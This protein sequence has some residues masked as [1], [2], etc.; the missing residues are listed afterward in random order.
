M[1]IHYIAISIL[2]VSMVIMGCITYM[3]SLA[4]EYSQ[5]IDV[6]GLNVSSV[7]RLE[8][9]SKLSK[10][11]EDDITEFKIETGVD[12]LL[13]PYQFFKVGWSALKLQLASW[14]TMFAIITDGAD[15]FRTTTGVPLPFWL[16]NGITSIIILVIV[17]IV[18]YGFFK[19]KFED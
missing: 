1:K 2:V 14:S 10:N 16:L 3:S 15:S 4:T 11:L 19:W 8:N 9:I 7:D 6:S 12:V 5:T 17:A 18:I 13:V